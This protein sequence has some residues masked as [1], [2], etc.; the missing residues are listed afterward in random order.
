VS[1]N[2]F[3]IAILI[4]LAIG[5]GAIL[6]G[7]PFPRLAATLISLSIGAVVIGLLGWERTP[8]MLRERLVAVVFSSVS[9]AIA[10]YVLWP[11]AQT[12]APPSTPAAKTRGAPVPKPSAGVVTK[13][14]VT[15]SII[16]ENQAGNNSLPIN[17]TPDPNAGVTTYTEEGYRRVIFPGSFT[18][19]A[20]RT[21]SFQTLA[22]LANA[23]KW[24][25]LIA[26]CRLQETQAPEWLTPFA[27]EGMA[28]A[29]LGNKEA[30][31]KL[32]E[33]AK[34]EIADNPDYSGLVMYIE[35]HYLA[36]RNPERG[37]LL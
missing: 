35:Y 6:L 5:V 29:E 37:S 16:T 19:D 8:L 31:V 1:D 9:C 11:A 12:P 7:Q 17:P 22:G 26:A 14:P 3:V 13:G 24:Q 34:R 18:V 15:Q 4:P 27:F 25:E 10:M 33:Y 32:L 2:E 23:G 30:A 28:H 36:K 20:S 21:R